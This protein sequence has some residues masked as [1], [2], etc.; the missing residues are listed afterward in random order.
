MTQIS[1]D[2]NYHK[3]LFPKSFNTTMEED[4]EKQICPNCHN[5]MIREIEGAENKL[6]MAISFETGKGIYYSVL[7]RRF[8]SI[9]LCNWCYALMQTY[10]HSIPKEERIRKEKI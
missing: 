8:R 9:D 5:T 4:M 6:K 10:R 7:D 2:I 1:Q 3:A